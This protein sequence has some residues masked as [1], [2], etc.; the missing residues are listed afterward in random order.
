[1]AY[2]DKDFYYTKFKGK[3]IP[4]DEFPRL[5]DIAT[6]VVYELC[7][8]KP[9]EEDLITDE[10]KKACCYQ[11]E[12]LYEQ[13]GIDA[14]LGFSEASQAGSS[15]SLGD[16]SISSGNNGK[17]T[18]KSKDGIPVSAL[19]LFYLRR[20]GLMTRWAYAQYY[21]DKEKRHS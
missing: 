15:E 5:A 20:L 18:I 2:I 8:L 12:L 9:R 11:V 19:T 17:E 6:D 14:I 3:P 10:F 1:M 7:A 13:G 21:R 16:Y 4:D